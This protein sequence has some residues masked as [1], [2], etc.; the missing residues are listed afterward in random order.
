MPGWL[1]TGARGFLGRAIVEEARRT[2]RAPI[3]TIGSGDVTAPGVDKHI[4]TDLTDE[5]GVNAVIDEFEP[6]VVI[7]AAGRTPPA[8]AGE[9]YRVNI[10]G[11]LNLLNALCRLGSPMRVVLLGSAAELGPVPIEDLPV[12]EDYPCRPSDAYGMSKLLATTA[13]LAMR[14]PLDVVCARVFNPIGPRASTNQAFGYFTSH[15]ARPGERPIRLEVG[16][17]EARR[18][19]IDVRDVARA[20]LA[21]A[22]CGKPGTVYNVATG[23]SLRVG[24]GLDRLVALSGRKVEVISRPGV[25]GSPLDS[26]AD[27]SRIQ[28]DTSWR[29]AVTWEQSL[30]DLWDEARGRLGCH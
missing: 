19:F 11:T 10:L 29:P 23:R 8:T 28:T 1:V 30:A 12:S 7:H 24:Q 13:G 26:R 5:V 27:I 22:D 3:V 21:L 4:A 16:D 20:V 2:Q 25:P 15:L 6:N 18:D 17:L 9:Y 14:A